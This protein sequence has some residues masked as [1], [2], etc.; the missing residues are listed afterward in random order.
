MTVLKL[1]Y[2]EE[3]EEEEV[4]VYYVEASFNVN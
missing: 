1:L 4:E 2:G 3:E